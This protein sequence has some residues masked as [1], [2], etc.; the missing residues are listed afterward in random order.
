MLGHGSMW[1]GGDRDVA[2]T[3]EVADAPTLGAE[4]FE[5]N[6]SPLLQQYFTFPPYAND[7]RGFE[8]DVRAVDAADG[9]IDGRWRDNEIAPLLRGFDTP[10]RTPYQTRV[11]EEMV[12]REGFGDDE[13]PDLLFVNYKEIDYISHVWARDSPEMRD[14]VVAQDEALREFVRFLNR[15]VGRGNWVMAITADHGAMVPPLASGGLRLSSTPIASG[16]NAT[17]DHDGDTTRVV[18]TVQQTQIFV[19][20]AELR[21]NGYTL[22]QVAEYVMGLTKSEVAAPGVK[23]PPTQ[24]SDRALR[25]AFPSSIMKTLP[26]LPEARG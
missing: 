14:A 23:V 13:M 17:F 22:S 20:T 25:A 1:G 9:Q 12:M 6:L 5:W 16:I 15:Q 21:Q 26:C 4:T 8:R 24:S 10:A 19:N 7:V 2:V 18:D 11:L 3:R